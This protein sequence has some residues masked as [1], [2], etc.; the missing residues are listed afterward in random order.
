MKNEDKLK[1][2]IEKAVSRGFQYTSIPAFVAKQN[3]WRIA[4]GRYGLITVTN[5]GKRNLVCGYETILFS[6][7]FAKAYWGEAKVCFYCGDYGS[8]LRKCLFDVSTKQVPA[9][10]YHLQQCVLSDDPIDYYYQ[11][12]NKQ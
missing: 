6:H 3:V 10:Q 4:F 12:I 5:Q 9:W 7:D 8:G 11:F 2:V 1:K